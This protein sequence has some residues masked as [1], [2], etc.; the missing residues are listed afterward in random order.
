MN[1]TFVSKLD[2]DTLKMIANQTYGNYYE[3]KN[4][5]QLSEIYEE[6][7]LSSTKKISMNLSIVFLISALILLFVEWG[8]INTR[9]RTLP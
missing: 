8:M 6:I 2:S 5:S 4:E 9:Y 3:S 1:L 7:A